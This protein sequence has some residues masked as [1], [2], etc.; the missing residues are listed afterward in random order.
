MNIKRLNAI[1]AQFWSTRLH[2]DVYYLGLC[3][4]FAVALQ[5]FL[6]AGT[7]CKAGILHT[8]LYYK[9]HYCDIRG[10]YLRSHYRTVVPSFSL[11][12]ATDAEIKHIE[13]LLDTNTVKQIVSGLKQAQKEVDRR[14]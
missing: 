12:P 7:I 2:N 4:E 1:I 13:K 3:S 11:S 8:C 10:C 14:K 9:N 6:N 5:K